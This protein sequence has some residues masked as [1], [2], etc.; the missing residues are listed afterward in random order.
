[1]EKQL[2]QTVSVGTGFV[3][4]D[5]SECSTQ[6]DII[7]YSNAILPLFYMDDFVI[8][9][10]ES[11]LGIVEV[12]TK[13]V[14]GKISE[15]IEKAN[16][17]GKLIGSQIFNGIFGYESNLSTG[18]NSLPEKFVNSLKSNAGSVNNIA[19]GEDVF[20]KYW[21]AGLPQNS[22]FRTPPAVPH[23][24]FYK[25]EKLSFGYFISNLV[26]DVYIKLNN[27]PIPPTLNNAL[28]PIEQTKEAHRIEQYEIELP[29]EG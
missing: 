19:F 20:A 29:L 12:K 22:Y 17:N 4:G 21:D 6:I 25:L 11:V 1:L 24:S 26:E 14:T 10:R 3:I 27:E 15:M 16:K 13:I 7:I 28:Y 9:T 23:Y 18:S 2:P 8:V 5:D